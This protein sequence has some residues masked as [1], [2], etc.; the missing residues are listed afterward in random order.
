MRRCLI[1]RLSVTLAR[2]R[3]KRLRLSVRVCVR[4]LLVGV[5]AVGLGVGFVVRGRVVVLAVRCGDGGLR[6]W[7]ARVLAGCEGGWLW[8]APLALFVF[9]RA[10]FR[11]ACAVPRAC[12]RLSLPPRPPRPPRLVS[13]SGRSYD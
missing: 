6:V 7:V 8:P 10:S 12:P 1:P 9:S 4:L 3:T 13:P 2:S 11:R 5:R